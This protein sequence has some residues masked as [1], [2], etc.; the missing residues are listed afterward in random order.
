LSFNGLGVFRPEAG[1]QA[2]RLLLSTSPCPPEEYDSDH[3]SKGRDAGNDD[4]P[5][6]HGCSILR[7]AVRAMTATVR[8]D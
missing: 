4:H 3:D 6:F 8:R 5:E 2:P 1:L 7:R